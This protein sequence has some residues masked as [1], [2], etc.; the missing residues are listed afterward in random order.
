[1]VIEPLTSRFVT[2]QNE[3]GAM[4]PLEPLVKVGNEGGVTTEQATYLSLRCD[5]TQPAW[6]QHECFV[7]KP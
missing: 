2:L 4:L 6:W 1:M 5:I 7:L 3:A